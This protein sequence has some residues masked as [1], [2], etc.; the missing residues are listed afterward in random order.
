MEHDGV[1]VIDEG[2]GE[3]FGQLEGMIEPGLWEWDEEEGD[4]DGDEVEAEDSDEAAGEWRAA[5][6]K[7][8]G[9]R[10]DGGDS[11]GEDSGWD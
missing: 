5:R 7:L 4:G 9:R 3:D 10:G 8:T 1:E 6:A 2:V 11:D